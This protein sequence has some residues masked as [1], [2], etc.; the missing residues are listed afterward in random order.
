MRI[1]DMH[2]HVFPDAIEQKA[3]ENLRRHYSLN[4]NLRGRIQDLKKSVE[5]AGVEKVLI[6]ATATN[7]RQVEN[8]NNWISKLLNDH[9]FGF[10]TLHPDY[11][12]IEKETDR[13][14]GLGLKGI[15]LHPDFQRFNIDDEKAYPIY[16]AAIQ[17]NI[18][19]LMHMGD[20]NLDY[21]SPVRLARVLDKFPD[22]K[23]IAAHLGGYDRWEESKKYIVGRNVY[24]DTSSSLWRLSPIEATEIIKKHG[25]DKVVFGTDYPI[26]NH[27]D[28]LKRF[29]KLDLN[30]EERN[31][32]LYQNAMNLFKETNMI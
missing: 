23:V 10:G 1:I 14:L 16:K 22:L 9:I 24:L 4:I 18:Y 28:E 25:V 5:E 2:A 7:A 32:I 12:D 3:V 20:K 31:K 11:K 6:L 17:R 21:S 8:I 30:Q 27:T 29:E 13:M 19:I 26:T 15:K